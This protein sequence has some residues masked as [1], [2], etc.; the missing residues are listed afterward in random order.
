MTGTQICQ[1]GLPEIE[2]TWKIHILK[3]LHIPRNGKKKIKADFL[4][5]TIFYQHIIKA[6]TFTVTT[7]KSFL[8]LHN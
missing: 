3:D 8:W 2:V 4:L 6:V 5:C 7:N 1:P